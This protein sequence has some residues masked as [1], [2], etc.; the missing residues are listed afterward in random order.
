MYWQILFVDI[1]SMLQ[2]VSKIDFW[3]LC[4]WNREFFSKNKNPLKLNIMEFV[5]KTLF[6]RLI[7]SVPKIKSSHFITVL[8]FIVED[9]IGVVT[10]SILTNQ[11]TLQLKSA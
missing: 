4:S 1:E 6:Q 8:N 7:I 10:V 5:E 3:D 9:K 2:I 11:L